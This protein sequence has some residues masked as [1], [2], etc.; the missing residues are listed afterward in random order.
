MVE[1]LAP[2]R[3]LSGLI[4]AFNNGAD[5]VYCG[6]KE[7]SMRATAKN[8][9]RNEL[10]EGINFAHDADKRVYLCTNTVVY[11]DDI[12]NL[13]EILEF[14]KSAEVDAVIVNDIGAM[15]LAKELGLEVHVSVQN[16]IT[17][18]KTAEFFSKFAKRVVLSRELTLTQIKQ[19]KENL[20]VNNVDLELE[21]FIHGALCTAMSGRCYLSSYLFNRNAN[22]GDCLQPCRRSWKLVNEHADGT[23][24]LISEGKYLLSPKDL[25]M[26]E[27]IPEM[28]DVFDC[29][30][31]EGRAK[32]VD[33]VMRATKTYR[34]AIDSVIDGTYEEKLPLFK[35]ELDKIYNRGYD[36]GF[37]FRDINC[38]HDLQ[39]EFEGNVSPYKKIE[40]GKV[41]NYFKKV[42]VAEITLIDNLNVGDSVLIIGQTTGCVEE[43]IESMQVE[44][45]NIKTAKKGQNVGIKLENLVRENDKVYILKED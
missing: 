29:F 26:I 34:E 15:S 42:G 13:N 43:K 33:Y 3:D 30:K 8:F 23:H 12:L 44:G 32:N 17:N 24:E 2:A 20:K 35:K 14:A 40:V 5:S 21:G 31:I 36:T 38:T 45:E 10:I 16:N 19:I 1:L 6:L 18:S 27:H 7:M 39:Y 22:C 25:C 11:E 41:V 9:E 28:I 37:Y 4:T